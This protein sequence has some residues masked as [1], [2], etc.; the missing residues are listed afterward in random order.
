M[1]NDLLFEALARL[2]MGFLDPQDNPKLHLAL[3]YLPGFKHSYHDLRPPDLLMLLSQDQDARRQIRGSLL[4]GACARLE[5]RKKLTAAEEG[6][7]AVPI[8]L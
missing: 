3:K 6:K 8:Q 4:G 7:S 5:A 1:V 2:E